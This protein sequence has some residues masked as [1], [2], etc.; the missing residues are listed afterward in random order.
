MALNWE[1]FQWPKDIY[2]VLTEP[3][4]LLGMRNPGPCHHSLWPKFQN[5]GVNTLVC[6]TDVVEYDMRYLRHI[7]QPLQNLSRGMIPMQP[8]EE[9]QK[10]QLIANQVIELLNS[11]SGVVIHCEGGRGRT[12]TVM[13]CVL[14]GLG[15]GEERAIEYLKQLH[16]SRGR[17]GWPESEWQEDVVRRFQ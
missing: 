17:D 11:R 13:G 16:V 1:P 9:E 7:Y 12:G 15:Y 3:A 6:L 10:I 14:K 8:D 2:L 5:L 4:F